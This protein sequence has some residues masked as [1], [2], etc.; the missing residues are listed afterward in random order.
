MSQ[1]HPPLP[2][3]TP[4]QQEQ[5]APLIKSVRA[6][7]LA[8]DPDIAAD[9]E[10]WRDL[11]DGESDALELIRAL[12]RASIDADLL[13]EAARKRQAEIAGRADRA[14][15]R[16]QACRAAAFALMDLAGVAKLPQPDF[17]AR[18]QAGPPQL[19]EKHPVKPWRMS[20]PASESLHRGV[21]AYGRKP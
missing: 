19:A 15:R 3:L 2:T 16:K 11:L 20:I 5:A 8:D 14:E 6:R 9:P 18:I 4:Y 7:L 17:L 12:I 1:P 13:A 21:P 10:L